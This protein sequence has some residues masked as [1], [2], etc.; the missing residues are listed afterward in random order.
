MAQ[1]RDPLAGDVQTAV[2]AKYSRMALS[3]D[4]RLAH[5]YALGYALTGTV[6]ATV[7]AGS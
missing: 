3:G 4:A 6:D 5:L 1:P 7:A 2:L